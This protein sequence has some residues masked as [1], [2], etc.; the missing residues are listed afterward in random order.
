MMGDMPGGRG[1]DAGVQAM[2]FAAAWIAIFACWPLVRTLIPVESQFAFADLVREHWA[3][4]EALEPWLSRRW[5]WLALHRYPLWFTLAMLPGGVAVAIVRGVAMRTA[6]PLLFAPLGWL[7]GGGIG[8]LLYR[9]IQSVNWSAAVLMPATFA[10]LGG[11]IGA[12]LA[13][14]PRRTRHIRGTK[15]RT[16][17]FGRLWRL[18][19]RATGRVTLAGVP[20][21]REDETMHVAA[22]GATGSGKSTALRA[23]MSDAMLRGDRHIVADPEGTAMNLFRKEG[24]II[25]NPF[26]PDCARWDLLAEIEAPSD[27][28][29]LAASLLPHLG[30]GDQDQWIT[31]AQQLLAGALETFVTLDLGGSDE[32]AAMMGSGKIDELRALCAGMPASRYFEPGG[33]RMLASIL[34]TLAPAIGH[35]RMIASA[36]GK[37]FSVRR[38]IREG[39]S[40][41]WIPYSANQIAALR[42]LA[43]CWMNIAILETLSLEPSTERRIWFHVDEL[44]ALGRIEGLQDAQ[45]RLRKFG[46]CV[47]IGFQSF[48]QVKQVYGEGAQTIVENCG[49]LLLL[50]SGT[51]EDGGTAKLASELIG[52]RE[53]E[54]DD[55]SRSRTRGKYAT[56]S[57]SLQ[58]KRSI[59]DV[60]LA[61]EVGQLRN[62]EGFVKRA[63]D[64]AW[65]RTRF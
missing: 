6:W 46:G 16:F 52:G 48:A 30:R 64:V 15:L 50:R 41:L 14:M 60:V 45:A 26:H 23:L 40:A 22:I 4:R 44:D 62:L 27:Y 61:S 7:G 9:D 8:Y 51:S 38:W 32:F 47:V 10:F 55:I 21:S 49:N 34:G 5:A 12:R 20:L 18:W 59:D 25:L 39:Q 37:P 3:H 29:F 24:D 57:T 36:K 54:R 43:S 33:E 35:L 63:T 11:A 58:T 13:A 31:Y 17:R 1:S 56:R 53:V 28:A 65:V 2:A 19:A 42:G